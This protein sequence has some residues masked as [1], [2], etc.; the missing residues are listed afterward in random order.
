MA[1]LFNKNIYYLFFIFIIILILF[2]IYTLIKFEKI[3]RKFNLFNNRVL[4]VYD[5]YKVITLC[6][7][8]KFKKEFEEIQKQ[9]TLQGYIVLSVG[10]FG[11]SGDKDLYTNN[12]KEMLDDLHKR[13]IDLANIVIIINKNNYIGESTKSEIEYA[14]S[15]KKKIIYWY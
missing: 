8:T 7:S 1:I 11:H 10:C 15:T 14:K 4:S 3:S 12:T 13:K 5:K 2:S 9:L 6:G